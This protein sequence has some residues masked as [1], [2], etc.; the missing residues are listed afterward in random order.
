MF[1]FNFIYLFEIL[2]LLYIFYK[3]KNYNN[4]NLLIAILLNYTS[5][6]IFLYSGSL[7]INHIFMLL[8]DIVCFLSFCKISFHVKFK[9]K[10]II[11]L[12]F[13]IL[14]LDQVTRYTHL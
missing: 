8:L 7:K 14:N 12:F 13:I 5:T 2:I 1:I 6:F 3:Y 9:F 11:I 4:Y 10:Q